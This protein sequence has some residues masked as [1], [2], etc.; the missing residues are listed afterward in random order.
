MKIR[1]EDLD[2]LRRAIEKVIERFP[3]ASRIYQEKNMSL[4]RYRW[5]LL[6]A[7]DMD[8]NRLYMYLNDAHI[9]TALR[10]IIPEFPN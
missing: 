4:N 7:S 9:E 3:S 6:H 8:K 5:D 1:P 2:A 10:R